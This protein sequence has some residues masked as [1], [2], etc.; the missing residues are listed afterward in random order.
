M[1]AGADCEVTADTCK[2]AHHAAMDF[3]GVGTK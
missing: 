1:L 2:D 3:N